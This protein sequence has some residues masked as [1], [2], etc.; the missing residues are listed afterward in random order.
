MPKLVRLVDVIDAIYQQ[1]DDGDVLEL[2]IS[3]STF[4]KIMIGQQL[5]VTDKTIRQKYEQIVYSGL[6]RQHSTNN[7][8]IILDVVA[9]R[10]EL[11]AEGRIPASPSEIGAERDT[12][13]RCTHTVHTPKLPTGKGGSQ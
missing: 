3:Y 9:I 2:P 7:K 5:V 6:A 13:T 11:R 4:R 10:N 1:I 8:I 12:H